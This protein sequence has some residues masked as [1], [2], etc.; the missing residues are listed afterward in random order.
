MGTKTSG[1]DAKLPPGTRFCRCM[2]CGKYFN[3]PSAFVT[4]M[5]DGKCLDARHMRA[6][7]MKINERGYWIESGWKGDDD[8]G[9]DTGG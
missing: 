4:H 3:S 6:R 9:T 8:G 1:A 7:G 2:R 5:V